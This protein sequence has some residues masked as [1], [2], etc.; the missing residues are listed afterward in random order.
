MLVRGS[1]D[2]VVEVGEDLVGRQV[3]AGECPDGAAQPAH[4]GGRVDAVAGHLPHHQGDAGPGQRD[5][6]E[7]VAAQAGQFVGRPVAGGYLDGVQVGQAVRQQ[8]ALEHQGLVP[9]PGVAAGVVHAHGRTGHEIV[10]QAEV[11]R[12]EGFL[13]AAPEERGHSQGGASCTHRH[14]HHAVQ[15]E[16]EERGFP[17]ARYVGRLLLRERIQAFRTPRLAAGQTAHGG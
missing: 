3:Q 5:D 2:Q 10:R 11:V 15:A 13:A 4:R 16:F 9:F 17:A 8:A 1:A 14:D 7:P 6:V 12:V